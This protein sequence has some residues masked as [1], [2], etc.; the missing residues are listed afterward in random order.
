M[1]AKRKVYTFKT[2]EEMWQHLKIK[3]QLQAA[4]HH[5]TSPERLTEQMKKR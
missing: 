1:A 2:E 4:K 3:A 5:F